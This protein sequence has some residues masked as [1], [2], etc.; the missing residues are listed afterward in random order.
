MSRLIGLLK[1]GAGAGM[2]VAAN[3]GGLGTSGLAGGEGEGGEAATAFTKQFPPGSL[4]TLVAGMEI[5]A[6]EYGMPAE[7]LKQVEALIDEIAAALHVS[8]ALLDGDIS[9]SNFASLRAGY[10]ADQA[11]FDHWC[12][13]WICEF[14]LPVFRMLATDAVSRRDL[15]ATAA[16]LTPRWLTPLGG[17]PNPE[18]ELAA[19]KAAGELGLADVA[20][21]RARRG[22]PADT[23]PLPV[24]APAPHLQLVNQ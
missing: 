23:A 9:R 5:D 7:T 13:K 15:P 18:K 20:A 12:R 21:E 3:S 22:V 17:E 24:P 14:R 10:A 8:R 11:T 16:G 19:F 6:A 2:G 4:P 1:T